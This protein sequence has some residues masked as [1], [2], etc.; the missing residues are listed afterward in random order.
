MKKK[1]HNFTLVLSGV[2]QK[3]KGLE[4]ILF[5]AGCD[6]ALINFRNGA[7]YL[8]FDRESTSFEKAVF[9]AIKQVEKTSLKIKVV[10][11]APDDYVTESDVAKRLHIKRQAVSLWFNGKRHSKTDFPSPVMKLTE[12]SPLWRW[13]DIVKWLYQQK[14]ITE[15][16]I[17]DRAHFIE[18]LN[19]ALLERDT[20]IHRYKQKIVKN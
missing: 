13:S 16:E 11:V 9:S 1:L 2:N 8:E 5:Q 7:V 18:S 19:V 14:K 10:N 17:L 15:A 6:D 4:D 20:I 3:T 12:K